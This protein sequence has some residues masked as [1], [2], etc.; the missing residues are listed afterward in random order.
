MIRHRM[1]PGPAISVDGLTKRYGDRAAV[2]GVSFEVARGE[3][4]G[5]LGPNGAG[6]TTTLEMIEGLR[7]PDGGRVSV[8][9]EPV[10]PSP[11]RIQQRIGV[12]LQATALFDRLTARE[13]LELF[14]TFYGREDGPARADAVL[15]MVG[16]EAKAGAY[17]EDMSGGQQQRL[18]IALALVHDPEVVFLDEPTT[19]LDPQARRNLWDVVRAIGEQ[20]GKTV[21]LTTHYLEEAEELC[22][23]VAIMDEAHVIALD[24]P[25]AL[26]A[27]L[28]TEARISY[29][30]DGEERTQLADDAQAAVLEILSRAQADGAT[31]ERLTVPRRQPRGR[32]S[33]PDRTGVPRVSRRR[34]T[35]TTAAQ[36]RMM[37]RRRITLFWSLVFP[38][39]L[40]TLLGVLFGGTISGG[41]VVVVDRAGTKAS[42]ELVAALER[43]DAIDVEHGDDPAEARQ[44]V[45]DG[46]AEGAL[47][48]TP[49]D[50][51]TTAA[52][53]STSNA[54]ATQ[55]AVVEGIVSGSADAVSIKATGRPPAVAVTTT[56]VDSSSLDYVDFLMPGIVALSIMISA[57]FG[58]STV[59][60]DWRKRGILRR[61]RL[62]P[63]PLS[64]F[65]VS[66][67]LAS[68]VLALLQVVVLVAFG[69]IAFGI[70]IS[71][72]AMAA[73]PVALAGGVCFL[74]IGFLIGSLVSEPE[75][76]DAV[77]N[78]VTNPMMFLSGTFFPVAAMPE[79]LQ[80]FA[81]LLPL[82]YLANGLRDTLVRGS[83]LAH[84]APEIG[85]LLAVTAVVTVISVR[86]FRWE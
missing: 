68:L 1:E 8:L 2:N 12:Q 73:I 21:V 74:A 26:V 53:L 83:S 76:A 84:V 65:L 29:V 72:T 77:T 27:T 50:G 75:T 86:T 62:T 38:I 18:A 9:G 60:V 57:V 49:G 23:R 48:L 32:V 15:D 43:S 64:E 56:S 13:L 63:M 25:A 66:R 67:V 24:T 34:L 17:A 33:A 5:I 54:S 52:Q 81:K 55:A 61:L 16:L 85:V 41:T 78:V 47:V 42:A 22:D 79:V 82:Y 44:D 10:W 7:R 36:L 3:A 69:A 20:G 31:V 35:A 51:G 45:E 59:M 19:G 46:D 11:H 71:S 4:F 28:G 6:K 30:L 80:Q 58:I 37:F 39:I 14:A 40:M 70:E